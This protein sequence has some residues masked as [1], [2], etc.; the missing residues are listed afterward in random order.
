VA[1]Q[2][3]VRRGKVRHDMDRDQGMDQGEV[4]LGGARQGKAW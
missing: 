4:R 1:R 3:A 2:G